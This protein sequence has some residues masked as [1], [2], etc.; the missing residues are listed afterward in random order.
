MIKGDNGNITK[1]QITIPK[2]SKKR[3]LNQL[4]DILIT[5]PGDSK[6]VLKVPNNG[7]FKSIEAKIR[8]KISPALEKLI[9]KVV[10]KNNIRIAN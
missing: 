8:V 5:Q 10:G 7:D 9:S 3:L 2:G 6:V 4:K 1:L